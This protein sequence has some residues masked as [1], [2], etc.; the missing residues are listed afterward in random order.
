MDEDWFWYLL[1][2]GVVAVMIALIAW[3]ADRRRMRRSNPDAVGCLPWRDLAFWAT[4]AAVLLL[5]AAF[6]AWLKG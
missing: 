6:R 3:G 2:P 5:G 1:V 4:F